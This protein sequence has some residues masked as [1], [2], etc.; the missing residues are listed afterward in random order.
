MFLTNVLLKFPKFGRTRPHRY[1]RRRRILSM[2]GHFYGR[3]RKCFKIAIK[4]VHRSFMHTRNARKN[5]R[6]LMRRI[7]NTRLQAA[8]QEF[9]VEFDTMRRTLLSLD[10]GLDRKILQTFAIWEPRTF[11]GLIMLTKAKTEVQGLNCLDPPPKG[12]I[13]RGML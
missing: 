5:R 6:F 8:C 3:R 12:V 13:T 9:G 2:A 1:W 4:G 11:R 10:I 7:F